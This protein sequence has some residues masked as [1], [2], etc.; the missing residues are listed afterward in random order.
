M[1]D[2]HCC[3][4]VQ[5]LRSNLFGNQCRHDLFICQFDGTNLITNLQ[6]DLINHESNQSNT[7]ITKSVMKKYFCS[8]CAVLY[9][10]VISSIS[11]CVMFSTCFEQREFVIDFSFSLNPYLIEVLNNLFSFFNYLNSCKMLTFLIIYFVELESFANDSFNVAS[12]DIDI[13]FDIE[14]SSS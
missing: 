2:C 10:S 6:E 4:R 13:I 12:H 7:S 11:S 3:F 1:C 14:Q 8:Y 9:C 5:R